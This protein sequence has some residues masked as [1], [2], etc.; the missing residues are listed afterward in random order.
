MT[1]HELLRVSRSLLSAFWVYAIKFKKVS[2]PLALILGEY[3]GNQPY[4]NQ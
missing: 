1:E 3:F 2:S 4:I